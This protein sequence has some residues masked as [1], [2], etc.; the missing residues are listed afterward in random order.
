LPSQEV[1][2]LTTFCLKW[3]QPLIRERNINLRQLVPS[4]LIS[5]FLASCTRFQRN[6]DKEKFWFLVIFSQNHPPKILITF[7][8]WTSTCPGLPSCNR[9]VLQYIHKN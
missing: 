1:F 5:T 8:S 4:P 6:P 3:S 2:P 7:F 9:V